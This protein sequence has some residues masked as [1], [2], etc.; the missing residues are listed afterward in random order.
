MIALF[1]E[2][3]LFFLVLFFVVP[4]L[5]L[6]LNSLHNH[7]QQQRHAAVWRLVPPG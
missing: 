7:V 5:F 4:G 6:S 2:F 1:F 3:T